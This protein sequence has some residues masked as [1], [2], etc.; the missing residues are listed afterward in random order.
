MVVWDVKY[1]RLKETSPSPTP[2]PSYLGRPIQVS[3]IHNPF[4]WIFELDFENI[5][6]PNYLAY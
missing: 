4:H 3:E 5:L 2:A 6:L 1:Y